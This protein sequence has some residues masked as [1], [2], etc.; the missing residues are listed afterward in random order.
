MLKSAAPSRLDGT[1]ESKVQ[2]SGQEKAAVTLPS[3]HE[4][5]LRHFE[6]LV[7][8]PSTRKRK[9]WQ[10]DAVLCL[11]A[12]GDAT[13][14]VNAPDV[15]RTISCRLRNSELYPGQQFRMA[16]VEVM[17]LQESV[18]QSAADASGDL[19][20]H[21]R[22]SA[23]DDALREVNTSAQPSASRSLPPTSGNEWSEELSL[24]PCWSA[25]LRPHQREGVCFLYKCISGLNS[26]GKYG[27]VLADEMGLGKSVQCIA[28]VLALM[29]RYGTPPLLNR[30]LLLAPC[31][32]LANWRNEIFKWTNVDKRS[33]VQV[34]LMQSKRDIDSSRL[35]RPNSI[36]LVS[37]EMFL[38]NEQLFNQCRIDLL[39]C[40]EAHRRILLTG[41]PVQNNLCELY[42]LCDFANPGV[43]G[44]PEEFRSLYV[45]PILGSMSME[46]D[47]A[48]RCYGR[49]KRKRLN[50]QLSQF[51]LRRTQETIMP[52]LPTK[53]DYAVFCRPSPLQA[54]VYRQI[55]RLAK[56]MMDGEII[57]SRP[58][59][60]LTILDYMRKLCNHPAIL[61][62][63]CQEYV[64]KTADSSNTVAQ[65]NILDE[66]AGTSSVGETRV[67]DCGK[68][69]V[70]ANLLRNV[71]QCYP[72][73]KV[74]IASNFT[75][76]LNVIQS[77][78]VSAGYSLYRLD[79]ST[80][81]AARQKMV[82]S[83]NSESDRTFLFLLSTKAGGL[84]LNLIGANRLVLYDLD[85]NPTF[86]K[87]A[88]A[89]V[90]RDG[91]RR[92]C[93]IYRL[94]STGTIEECI[95]QRQV[96]KGEVAQVVDSL[97]EDLSVN[98]LQ[99]SLEDLKNILA[100]NLN[101]SCA[102]HDLLACCCDGGIEEKSAAEEK[103]HFCS[104]KPLYEWTHLS[105]S[106]LDTHS[107]KDSCL[108]SFGGVVSFLFSQS[109]RS[110][111]RTV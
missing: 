54:R 104:V 17:V 23:S 22:T 109:N 106:L 67:E 82:D 46:A 26:F 32:L 9:H 27:A 84:G 21:L 29:K 45:K 44:L 7:G 103:L 79:G 28:L 73:E 111:F 92:V 24:D 36:L 37:Y 70:L 74:V 50:E 58:E 20:T 99:I 43:L 71:R 64:N 2:R 14:E 42:S 41:T 107:D 91:Q 4:N 102:T 52:Y 11:R 38:R 62:Y 6:V 100:L 77:Y 40:D 51:L 93:R 1:R 16:N 76:T 10:Y 60:H 15:Q 19:P 59:W 56:M 86:D 94:I 13:L 110:E 95:F 35:H 39:I 101:T 3:Q 53:V 108:R 34:V 8:K 75:E 5:C 83:F 68:L 85:W 98:C 72:D 49:L 80:S 96:K 105:G 12:R 66:F 63:S 90:W 65:R 33:Q 25:V 89:R 30:V 81:A 48:A 55:V 57:S 18:S 87:Q 88:M 78:C 47:D 69:F 97:I 61:F 31:S